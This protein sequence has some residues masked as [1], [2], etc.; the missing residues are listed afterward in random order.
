MRAAAP[1]LRRDCWRWGLLA[2]LWVLPAACQAPAPSLVGVRTT[3]SGEYIIG[4]GDEVNVFVYRAPE[5]S[6]VVPVRPDGRISTPLVPDVIAVGRT[7]TQLAREIEGRLRQYVKEPNVTVMVTGFVGPPERQIRVI[8]E[9]T[10]PLAIP[11]RKGL[12]VLDVMIAAKGLTRFA[13][14]NRALL[15]RQE[16]RGARTYAIRLDDLLKDGDISQNVAMQPGDTVFVPQ[17]WF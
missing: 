8:G 4:P 14:G 13:A 16:P 6:A 11:Y 7:P 2:C 17:A 12:S 3:P 5:L 10:E 9:V 1:I 15:V